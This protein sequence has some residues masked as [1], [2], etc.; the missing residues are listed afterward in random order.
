MR[1]KIAGVLNR[2]IDR[3]FEKR[4]AANADN[5]RLLQEVLLFAPAQLL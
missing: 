3:L 2:L 1:L 4:E 5:G